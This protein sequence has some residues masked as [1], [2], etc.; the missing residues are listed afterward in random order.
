LAFGQSLVLMLQRST[1]GK[2]VLLVLLMILYIWGELG[3]AVQT[4]TKVHSL[5]LS[6]QSCPVWTKLG[7]LW[8]CVAMSR[9]VQNKVIC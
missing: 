2:C 3:R 4:S 7:T 9:T 1:K 5:C 6:G 8:L